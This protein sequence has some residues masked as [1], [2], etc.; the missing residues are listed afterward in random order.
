MSL[1]MLYRQTLPATV[2]SFFYTSSE[3][4]KKLECLGAYVSIKMQ[5]TSQHYIVEVFTTKTK[6]HECECLHILP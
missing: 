5:W 6:R 3:R 4:E 2:L 1:G